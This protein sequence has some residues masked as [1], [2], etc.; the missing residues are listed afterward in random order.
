[1]SPKRDKRSI[2]VFS[3]IVKHVVHMIFDYYN[4]ISSNQERS[5]DVRRFFEQ[6]KSGWLPRQPISPPQKKTPES[7]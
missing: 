2:R 1:M 4:I 3:E 7:L 5:P 6:K